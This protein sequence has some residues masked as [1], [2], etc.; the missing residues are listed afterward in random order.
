MNDIEMDVKT[1]KEN[2]LSLEKK[3]VSTNIT[4]QNYEKYWTD[5]LNVL[6]EKNKLEFQFLTRNHE[7][8]QVRI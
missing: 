3:L 4:L 6:I 1:L 7:A 5:Q 2:N 8:L